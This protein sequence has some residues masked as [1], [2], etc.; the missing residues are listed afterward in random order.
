MND[1]L[2]GRRARAQERH[3]QLVDTKSTKDRV[4]VPFSLFAFRNCLM[5]EFLWRCARTGF[6]SRFEP[7]TGTVL[8]LFKHMYIRP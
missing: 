2:H 3:G 6:W 8:L 4:S 7:G 5:N 1:A